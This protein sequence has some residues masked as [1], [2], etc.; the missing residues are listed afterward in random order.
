MTRE[1]RQLFERFTD[2]LVHAFAEPRR[3][4]RTRARVKVGHTPP[5]FH[6]PRF[7]SRAAWLAWCERDRAAEEREEMEGAWSCVSVVPRAA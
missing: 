1:G 6:P 5:P 3:R 2:A 7:R 4:R